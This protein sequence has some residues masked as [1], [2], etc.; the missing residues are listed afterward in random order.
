MTRALAAIGLAALLFTAARAQSTSSQTFEVA[1]VHASPGVTNLFSR[2]MFRGGRYEI[3]NASI[4]DLIRIAYGVE[5]SLSK[6]DKMVGGPKRV[7]FDRVEVI[8]EAAPK[9][10][11][12]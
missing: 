12:R 1:D 6:S 3:H 7:D 11:P 8:T 10:P 2:T 4:V 5:D 9:T